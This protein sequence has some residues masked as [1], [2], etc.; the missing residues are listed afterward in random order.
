MPIL[1][2]AEWKSITRSADQETP[3]GGEY[4]VDFSSILNNGGYS[5]VWVLLN[6]HQ[7]LNKFIE[8]YGSIVFGF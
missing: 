2:K 3:L 7:D 4:S 6:Y 1:A 8:F 5:R